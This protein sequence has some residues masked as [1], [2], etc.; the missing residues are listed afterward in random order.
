METTRVVSEVGGSPLPEGLASMV[1]GAELAALLASI[2]R[3]AV[4]SD[5]MLDVIAA[6]AR[7]LWH[8]QAE[9]FSD[10]SQAVSAARAADPGEDEEGVADAVG[11]LVGWT[12]HWATG[13]AQGQVEVGVALA[14]RLPMVLA[15]L[16]EGQ[17]DPAKAFAFVDALHFLDDE[18]A[19]R[20]AVRL[21]PKARAWTLSELRA[22]L[23]YHV[24]RADPE[25]AR[26]RYKK[27]V[28]ER[29]VYLRALP[30][31]TANLSGQGLAPHRAAAAFD[32]LDRLA[33]AARAGG[34][35]RNLAQLRADAMCDVL[36]G[37]PFRLAPTVDPVTAEAD[38]SEDL[39][40]LP[41]STPNWSTESRF[42]T[43]KTA[44]DPDAS[45][46]SPDLAVNSPDWTA[47]SRSA[48]RK[49]DDDPDDLGSGGWSAGVIDL[50]DYD[51][52]GLTDLD[53]A[54]VDL[55]CEPAGAGEDETPDWWLT[56]RPAE[57]AGRNG[58]GG[59]DAGPA[60]ESRSEN[61]KPEPGQRSRAAA[62]VDYLIHDA[63]LSAEVL[64]GDRCG[65]CGR[66]LRVRPGV[67]DVQVKLTTLMG[68][69]EHPA[70]IPGFGV[71]LAQ[72]A[73]QVAFDSHTRPTWRW[74][75]FD[76]DGELL[77]HGLTHHRPNPAA[78]ISRSETTKTA[79]PPPIG[80]PAP[81]RWCACTRLEPGERR[82]TI[83]LQLTP[84]TLDQLTTAPTRA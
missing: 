70:L 73:R 18:V 67:V 45:S 40:D 29:D 15:A 7:L 20:I 34:D 41:L 76:T 53:R 58:A 4:G 59:P 28:A 32:R 16:R 82:G 24:D 47:E 33:R 64:P 11:Q 39:P 61:R 66:R 14:R 6:R 75:I 22:S 54:W 23:R 56:C 72:I 79:D 13:Y 8:L 71:T 5:S 50:Y 80:E 68:L 43:R 49:T 44:N 25:A 48:T 26:R 36:A 31:G 84:D 42:P 51:R 74:S 55:G 2:D 3:S 52:A 83:E 69:D 27:R 37:I 81:H 38:A 77:H 65:S 30:D 9:F 62:Q 17:L 46:A 35:G 10:M 57:A 1:P 21:L 78:P 19:A 60:E 63:V 12:L